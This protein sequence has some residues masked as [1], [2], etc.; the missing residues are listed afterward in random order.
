MLSWSL[1]LKNFCRQQLFNKHLFNVCSES[2]PEPNRDDSQICIWNSQT[3]PFFLVPNQ[4]L[5]QLA[6]YI[7]TFLCCF[8]IKSYIPLTESF[9]IFLKDIPIFLL[10]RIINPLIHLTLD[11]APSTWQA[12]GWVLEQEWQGSCRYAA[13]EQGINK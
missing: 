1:S 3:W 10:Y 7:F 4:I 2:S 11:L 12:F 6:G 13:F 9:L 8:R 5:Q